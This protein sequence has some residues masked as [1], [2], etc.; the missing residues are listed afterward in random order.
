MTQANTRR[1]IPGRIEVHPVE[2][3]LV[4]N[5]T[6]QA[7]IIGDNGAPVGGDKKNMQKMYYDYP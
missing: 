6:V 1:I 7:T 3:S 5:Y 4:I 2:N